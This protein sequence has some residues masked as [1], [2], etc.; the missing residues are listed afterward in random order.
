VVNAI[1]AEFRLADGLIADH[2]D[3][4]DF[5]TWAKQALGPMG[6]LVAILPPLR[7][8]ARAQA[9]DQLDRFIAAE[10]DEGPA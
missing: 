3:D 6:N 5:R 9:R 2:V 1:R 7:N 8:K 10:K 4:F